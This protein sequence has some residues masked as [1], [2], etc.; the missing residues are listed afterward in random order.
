M[1]RTRTAKSAKACSD[2]KYPKY[3]GPLNEKS[4]KLVTLV[5]EK[6]LFKVHERVQGPKYVQEFHRAIELLMLLKQK[7]IASG[8]PFALLD[9]VVRSTIYSINL[10]LKRH[11]NLW[12]LY[13][14]NKGLVFNRVLNN[15]KSG[16]DKL[17]P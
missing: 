2:V 1:W 10:R 7:N 5:K 15:V 11:R 14:V 4:S 6:T 8:R 13:V 9:R 3:F 17:C 16:P 12:F